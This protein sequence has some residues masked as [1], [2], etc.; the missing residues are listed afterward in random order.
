MTAISLFTSGGIGDLAIRDGGFDILVSNEKLHERHA[1]FQHNFP[2]TL[3]ITGDI[4]K[5][6]D[7]IEERTRDRLGG[8]ELTLFYATPPC[9]GMSKNGR[10]K[11]LSEIRA[12]RKPHMDQ[13][14]RLIIP[15]IELA[16]CLQPEIVL[17]ENVPEM[18]DTIIVNGAG[19]AVNVIDF[20]RE[21]LGMHTTVERRWWSSPTM[22]YRSAGNDL[23]RYSLKRLAW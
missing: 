19:E 11:L 23:S 8:E 3:A 16:K 22:A 14:N 12:G 4:W 5:S 10:G 2:G 17:L 18:A 21:E 6:I 1:V 9:Q 7:R 15:T 13:R 20:I